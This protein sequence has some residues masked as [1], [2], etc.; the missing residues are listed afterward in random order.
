MTT[1]TPKRATRIVWTIDETAGTVTATEERYSAETTNYH[2]TDRTPLVFK[3][4]E[5][6]PDVQRYA[7]L[8]GMLNRGRDSMALGAGATNDEKFAEATKIRDHYL[9]GSADWEVA[10][11]ARAKRELTVEEKRALM[12]KWKAEGI[13]LA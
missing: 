7:T 8:L 6:H 1:T 9:T 2:A 10:R 5:F 13:D 4:L 12:A 11:A 3:P